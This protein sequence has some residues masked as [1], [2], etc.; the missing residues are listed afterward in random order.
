L[1]LETYCSTTSRCY[2]SQSKDQASDLSGKE[3]N[4]PQ[5][6]KQWIF[7]AKTRHSNHALPSKAQ[8]FGIMGIL[9]IRDPRDAFVSLLRSRLSMDKELRKDPKG[10]AATLFQEEFPKMLSYMRWN[11]KSTLEVGGTVLCYDQF[12]RSPFSEIRN[13]FSSFGFEP[14]PAMV[15]EVLKRGFYQVEEGQEGARVVAVQE[16]KEG[17]KTEAV[18]SGINEHL[19]EKYFKGFE[20]EA[21]DMMRRELPPEYLKL[22][23]APP[24]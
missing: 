14:S 7:S 13:A 22:F 19:K 17:G 10:T 9:I 3:V 24:S 18:F 23:L 11:I 16:R 6:G 12:F 8:A 21:E 2:I 4:F 1:I 5:C 15:D 20:E